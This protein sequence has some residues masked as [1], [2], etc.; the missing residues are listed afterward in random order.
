M[1]VDFFVTV[2]CWPL[3]FIYKKGVK[4]VGWILVKN[5]NP[6]KHGILVQIQIIVDIY[7]FHMLKMSWYV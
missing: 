6:I 2:H 4:L 5:I 7:F 3:V 1:G